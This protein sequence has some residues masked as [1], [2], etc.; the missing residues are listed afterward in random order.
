MIVAGADAVWSLQGN[1]YLSSVKPGSVHCFNRA[2]GGVFCAKLNKAVTFRLAVIVFNNTTIINTSKILE[3]FLEDVAVNSQRQV[4]DSDLIPLAWGA[5][6]LTFVIHLVPRLDDKMALLTSTTN[7]FPHFCGITYLT[8]RLIIRR[9]AKVRSFVVLY[10]LFSFTTA[11]SELDAI[12]NVASEVSL[13]V[14]VIALVL[15]LLLLM[16]LLVL[17]TVIWLSISIRL[18]LR[19][20]IIYIVASFRDILS[21]GWKWVQMSILKHSQSKRKLYLPT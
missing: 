6:S 17:S 14:I 16:Q 9:T 10:Q 15:S 18:M 5:T 19:A 11:T 13:I 4:V 20:M 1:L 8:N 7:I 2:Y 21:H 3:C 12:F